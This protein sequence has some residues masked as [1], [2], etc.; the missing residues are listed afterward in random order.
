MRAIP[1]SSRSDKWRT[2]LTSTQQD[3]LN[4]VIERH[5]DRLGYLDSQVNPGNA[6]VKSVRTRTRRYDEIAPKPSSRRRYAE[7]G[8][9]RVL[10]NT[11]DATPDRRASYGAG[12]GGYVRMSS[13]L[14]STFTSN[15]FE[16]IPCYHSVRRSGRFGF[17]RLPFRLIGDVWPVM[18]MAGQASAIHLTLQY[19]TAI[20]RE[21][22]ISVV[23]RFLRLPMLVDVRAGAFVE[24]YESTSSCGRTMARHVLGMAKEIA[25]EGYE[26]IQFIDRTFNRSSTYF[27]NFVPSSEIPESVAEKCTSTDLRVLFVGFAYDGKGVFELV[28]GCEQVA[29]QGTSIHLTLAGSESADFEAWLSK[30][31]SGSLT[32]DRLG[33]QDHDQVIELFK[34]HDVFCLPTRHLGEGHSNTINE[35]MMMGMVIVTTRHGFIASV[36][37]ES[38]CYFVDKNSPDSI[39]AALVMVDGDREGARK[40]AASARALL[41]DRYSSDTVIPVLEQIYRRLVT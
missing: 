2:E 3:S 30:R 20:F 24:W 1:A 23:A 14:L 7:V 28:E 35:A 41:R 18:R 16:I 33:P 40:K 22:A 13:V 4:D 25:V 36:L 31:P 11:P 34:T 38:A 26:Y 15:E 37:D 21:L 8:L 9:K 12:H 5:P 32:I 39:T 19:R 27:P 10:L 29:E 17:L 6:T